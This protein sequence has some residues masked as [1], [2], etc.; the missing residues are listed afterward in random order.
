MTAAVP[1]RC[2]AAWS[3]GTI[4]PHHGKNDGGVVFCGEGWEVLGQIEEG[5]RLVRRD[6]GTSR[7]DAIPS[8]ASLL[9]H[10]PTV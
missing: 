9:G 7:C 1:Q 3:L 5:R 8:T 2:T 4:G 10:A 6:A